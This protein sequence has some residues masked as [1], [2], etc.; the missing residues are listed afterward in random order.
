[1]TGED[2]SVARRASGRRE[3]VWREGQGEQVER[4]GANAKTDK[5]K[6]WE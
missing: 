1:M 6:G 2:V 5:M 3:Q 4:K